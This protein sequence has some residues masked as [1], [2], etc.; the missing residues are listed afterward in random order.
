MQKDLSPVFAGWWVVCA[1][2][3]WLSPGE[4]AAEVPQFRNVS[5]DAADA[6]GLAAHWRT[7]LMGHLLITRAFPHQA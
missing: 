3:G 2:I 6:K 5:S 7:Q 4:P 1:V